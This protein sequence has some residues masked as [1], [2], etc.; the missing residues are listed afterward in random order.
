MQPFAAV[1]PLEP[2][3]RE[4]LLRASAEVRVETT[5]TAVDGTEA[6]AQHVGCLAQQV[7]RLL[8]TLAD[9][10]PLLLCLPA[11]TSLDT[12]RAARAVGARRLVA[13]DPATFAR[14]LGRGGPAVESRLVAWALDG[15]FP[16]AVEQ[17]LLR[18]PLVCVP[19]A[20]TTVLLLR[21]VELVRVL[22]ATVAPLAA[23]RPA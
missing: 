10:L 6:L 16:V 9:G 22:R 12:G 13:S 18:D 14:H 23:G 5:T 20:A 19:V 4:A 17:I 3:L 2:A 15:A 8:P 1:E 21:P 11:L 7:V